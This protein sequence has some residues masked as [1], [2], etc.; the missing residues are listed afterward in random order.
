MNKTNNIIVHALGLMLAVPVGIVIYFV[1]G[2]AIAYWIGIGKF[3]SLPLGAEHISDTD[4]FVS[5]LF[6]IGL[7][8]IVIQLMFRKKKRAA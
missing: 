4:I 8:G 6:W 1:L 7:S 5:A 2:I 3:Y